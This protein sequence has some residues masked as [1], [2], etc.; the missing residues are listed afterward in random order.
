MIP[1][2]NIVE[3]SVNSTLSLGLGRLDVVC[4]YVGSLDRLGGPSFV[5]G[6]KRNGV[7]FGIRCT[8]GLV[9]KED[10]PTLL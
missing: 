2:G 7:M 9:L 8:P 5:P 6:E 3:N 10:V 4:S 1:S